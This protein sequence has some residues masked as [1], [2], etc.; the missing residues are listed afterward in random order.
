MV[1]ELRKKLGPRYL[2]P[3]GEDAF[4]DR[5]VIINYYTKVYDV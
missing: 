5:G 1:S 3:K 2:A 4:G